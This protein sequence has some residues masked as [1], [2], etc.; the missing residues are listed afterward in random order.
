MNKRTLS[1]LTTISFI[2][3]IVVNLI[4]TFGLF[5]VTPV[6]EISDEYTNLLVPM[7][8]TFSVIW[9]VIY[10][11]LLIYTGKELVG[12]EDKYNINWL[13][14]ISNVLNTLWII[15]FTNGLYLISCIT[16]AGL[17]VVLYMINSRIKD[18]N[19]T[20]VTFSIY[21]TWILVASAVNINYYLVSLN[22]AA[23][24]SVLMKIISVLMIVATTLIVLMN[25]N[26]IT[27]KITYIFA[28]TGIAVNHIVALDFAYIDMMIIVGLVIGYTLFTLLSE[29]IT[30]NR[31]DY[32]SHEAI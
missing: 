19:L 32:M 14:M 6:K 22:F 23:F 3:M 1:I 25:Y 2:L 18:T 11:L 12:K 8:Y 9:T 4:S 10:A 31:K 26:N 17:F 27:M 5:G 28:L 20:K 21:T 13:F 24:D 29:L 15:T 16:I 30:N 7:G